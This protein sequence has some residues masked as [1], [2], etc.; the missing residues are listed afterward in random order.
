MRDTLRII[1][2]N[3]SVSE[4]NI[5]LPI[6]KPIFM[7]TVAAQQFLISREQVRCAPD[8]LNFVSVT[9]RKP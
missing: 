3:I 8:I 9:S 5:K 6:N 1:W 4:L 7:C 2:G